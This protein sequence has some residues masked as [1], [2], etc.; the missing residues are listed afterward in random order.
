MQSSLLGPPIRLYYAEKAKLGQEAI[1]YA[2]GIKIEA[3]RLLG[4]FLKHAEKATGAKGIGPVAPSPSSRRLGWPRTAPGPPWRFRPTS[5]LQ[6]TPFS[7]G[8]Q[9]RNAAGR[10]ERSLGSL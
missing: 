7:S 5:G 1:D 6:P 3:Q 10:G 4:E 2:H 9:V 8:G